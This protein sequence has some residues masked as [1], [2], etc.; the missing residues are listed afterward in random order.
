[1]FL[2]WGS[3]VDGVLDSGDRELLV[4]LAC[5]PTGLLILAGFGH[6]ATSCTTCVVA[7]HGGSKG[8]D[9]MMRYQTLLFDAGTE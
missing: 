5:L 8:I 3:V 7:A 4:L 1:M 6:L 2:F 9:F